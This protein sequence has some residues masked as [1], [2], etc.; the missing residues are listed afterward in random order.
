[1]RFKVVCPRSGVWRWMWRGPHVL[2][3]PW[4]YRIWYGVSVVWCVRCSSGTSVRGPAW[5]WPLRCGAVGFSSDFC[6]CMAVVGRLM[7][8]CA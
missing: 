2:E 8:V 4:R 5:R 6:Q 1:M 3:L 7:I